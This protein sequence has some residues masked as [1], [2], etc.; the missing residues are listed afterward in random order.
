[1]DHAQE[2][3]ARIRADKIRPVPRWRVRLARAG[4]FVLF[5]G[6]VLSGTL[7]VAVAI[8]GLHAH[9]GRGWMFRR[10]VADWAPLLWSATFLLFLWAG[11]RL[12]R[13]LPRGWRVRPWHVALGIGIVSVVGGWAIER[14]DALMAVHH[15]VV[16]NV[17]S[18]REAWQ[19]KAMREWHDPKGGKLSGRWSVAD[20]SARSLLDMDGVPWTIRWTGGR[21]V[22][23]AEGSIRLIGRVCGDRVFCADDWRPVPGA[24]KNRRMR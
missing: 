17:P 18:Y 20:D 24:G 13:E 7:S 9:A 19:G 3:L 14:T 11:V 4:V 21:D 16:R 22:P 8:Q 5:A 23:P 1:M 6:T 12:F 10:I 2:L 15:A